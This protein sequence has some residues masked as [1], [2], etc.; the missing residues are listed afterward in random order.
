MG[1]G[2]PPSQEQEERP[3]RSGMLAQ[4]SLCILGLSNRIVAFPPQFF[5]PVGVVKGPV[6]I[7]RAFERL[8][9]L[10]ALPAF[11]GNEGRTPVPIQVPLAD[12]AGIVPRPAQHLGQRQRVGVQGHVVHEDPGGEG[13]L[14]SQQGG[15]R[16]AAHRHAREGV[17]EADALACQTVEV[18]RLYIRISGEAERL[19]PPLVRQDE[20]DVWFGAA[21]R[22]PS[23]TYDVSEKEN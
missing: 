22:L 19:R 10:E 2:W 13:P 16:G 14:A 21:L 3:G 8:P 17:D 12:V 5:P 1:H 23:P 11:T 15:P 9:V 4:V 18:R 6:V 20:E 7:V